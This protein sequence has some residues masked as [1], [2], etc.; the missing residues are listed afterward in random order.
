[1]VKER[2]SSRSKGASAAALAC[3][4]TTA[5]LALGC[6][7]SPPPAPSPGPSANGTAGPDAPS[8]TP[9]GD[10]RLAAALAELASHETY[11]FERKAQAA[12]LVEA[13][14]PAG[15]AAAPD[16]VFWLYRGGE[17]NEALIAALR[18]IGPEASSALAGAFQGQQTLAAREAA[19]KLLVQL[20]P[21]WSDPVLDGLR[22]ELS[23]PG[24]EARTR[25]L[26]SLVYFREAAARALPELRRMLVEERDPNVT[27]HVPYTIAAIGSGA[28]AAL[29]E[30]T[31]RFGRPLPMHVRDGLIKCFQAIGPPAVS[32]LVAAG[33]DLPDRFQADHLYALHA[34]LPS[35][36]P[37]VSALIAARLASESDAIASIA[38]LLLETQGELG[39]PLRADALPLLERRRGSLRG[40]ALSALLVSD[41]RPEEVPLLRARLLEAES[42]PENLVALGRVLARCGAPGR[43]ALEEISDTAGASALR[44]LV[45]VQGL[46]TTGALRPEQAA[47]RARALAQ[48]LGQVESTLSEARALMQ[49]LAS[50]LPPLEAIEILAAQVDTPRSHDAKDILMDWSG[51]E[52]P[53]AL[54]ALGKYM[55]AKDAKTAAHAAAL[56]SDEISVLVGVLQ[57]G[58]PSARRLAAEQLGDAYRLSPADHQTACAA[59][60]KAQRDSAPEVRAAAEAALAARR[61]KAEESN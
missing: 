46:V 29:P 44:R 15:A 43:G 50:L 24:I 27:P 26:L 49:G 18:A 12:R 23:A 57:T 32:P 1:M 61:R 2:A 4:L 35:A 19:A 25:A 58:S 5:L 42:D 54:V 52:R 3:G 30:L 56:L 14:G 13:A 20:G 37:S 11:D 45:A 34:L 41:G 33:R 10:E 16:L 47:V 22:A 53:A 6:P 59:L 17:L 36:E 48:D 39:A 7:E 51:P 9:A 8:P 31:A 28:S 21:R 38:C 55:S 60:E 40:L